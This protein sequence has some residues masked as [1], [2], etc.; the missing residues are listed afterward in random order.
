MFLALTHGLLLLPEKNGMGTQVKAKEGGKQEETVGW[1]AGE[2][3]TFQGL[4]T[5][6]RG[7]EEGKGRL[8]AS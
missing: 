6:R 7:G 4:Q 2:G 5:K 8:V 1:L 3:R